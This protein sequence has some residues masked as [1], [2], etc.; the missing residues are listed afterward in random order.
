M[1]DRTPSAL[2]DGQVPMTES[3]RTFGCIRLE[4]I[5]AVAR[6][7]IDRPEQR[8]ALGLSFAADIHAA[9]DVLEADGAGAVV[10][11]GSGTVFCAGGDL[12]EIM[13]PSRVD[14]VSDYHVIRGYN[15]VVSRIRQLDQVVIAAVNGPAVGGG[16]ALALACDLAVAAR[17]A[18]YHFAFE[19]I[20]LSAADMG[21]VAL[22]SRAIGPTRAAQLLLLSGTVD[23]DEGLRLA[24]FAEVH[25]DDALQDAALALATRLASGPRRANASTKLALNRTGHVDLDTAMEYEAFLQ[26]VRFSDSEHKTRL[27]TATPRPRV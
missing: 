3:S 21:C 14:P 10:L 24:L 25:E 4:T 27:S 8:N 5:G 23:A 1:I 20:G 9:L 19:R 26:A 13:E 22:L 11:T 18:R 17:S 2:R 12:R 16:A 6:V 15:R 7:V